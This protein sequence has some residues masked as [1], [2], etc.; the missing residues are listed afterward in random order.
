M[1][2]AGYEYEVGLAKQSA[3]GT[4]NATPAF[5]PQFKDLDIKSFADKTA[6]N[7]R[8]AS[9]NEA[10]SYITTA[11]Y[12]KVRIDQYLDAQDCA[13]FFAGVFGSVTSTT[14]GT[15]YLHTMDFVSGDPATPSKYWTIKVTKGGAVDAQYEDAFF[16]DFSISAG[17]K[18]A[19][20]SFNG[21]CNFETTGASITP[22]L[23]SKKPF[24]RH[25]LYV[26]V[27]T[28]ITTAL[29]STPIPVLEIK[30]DGKREPKA[31]YM[32]NDGTNDPLEPANYALGTRKISGSFK[33]KFENMT[34]YNKYLNNT[35]NAVVFKFLGELI[36]GSTY[37]TAEFR[38]P[39][40]YFTEQPENFNLDSEVL[41]DMKFEAVKDSSAGY[42]LKAL[43]TN[44]YAGAGY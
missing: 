9:A 16:H 34:Q 8:V 18:E 3:K 22:S 14:S 6:V 23:I 20:V 36:S 21:A 38:M 28:D 43:F 32:S 25:H 42:T 30:L 29:A 12:G 24:M 31:N 13:P 7:E 35:T 10:S 39:K 2:I 17:E 44:A 15:G 26:R 1:P 5:Y 27:G 4:P 11:K 41:I 40:V 37:Y 19:T 33:I